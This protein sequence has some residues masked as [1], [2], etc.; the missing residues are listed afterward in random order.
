M[1]QGSY[2]GGLQTT[3]V[4][5]SVNPFVS[6]QKAVTSTAPVPVLVP[7]VARNSEYGVADLFGRCVLR[8]CYWLDIFSSLAR[9]EGAL[10]DLRVHS[11]KFFRG[12]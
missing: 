3:S 6:N 12:H 5:A 10:P 8:V 1:D 2:S 11:R 7:V 4:E 9:R